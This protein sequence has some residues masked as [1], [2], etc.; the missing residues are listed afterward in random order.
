[1]TKVKNEDL[2]PKIFETT[3]KEMYSLMS[4]F[5]ESR[6]AK[7]KFS[8]AY[9]DE[10]S[11]YL[12]LRREFF[13]ITKSIYRHFLP[14]HAG[15]RILD[16]GCG[17]GLFVEEL[18]KIDS[19]I[20]VVLIDGSDD[21]L[22]AARERL[23][24]HPGIQ[25][26]RA[27]F[28]ELLKSDPLPNNFDFVFSSLAIHHLTIEEKE[29]LYSFIYDHLNSGGHFV[30]YDVVLSPTEGLEKWYLSL[31]SEWIEQKAHKTIRERVL[32]I[33]QQY[34]NNKDNTPDTLKSQMEA[35]ERIGFQNVDCYLKYGIFSLFGGKK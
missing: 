35:L 10:A 8:Q 4:T 25:F 34:K 11:A 32:P 15:N 9:R 29:R 3:A 12:P 23:S 2:T 26:I 5:S 31:W 30:H 14:Q 21:M 1:L 22:N 33:P 7:S 6:W 17:D 28:Q 18:L 24:L 20:E 13:E 16:L 27:G 19:Y